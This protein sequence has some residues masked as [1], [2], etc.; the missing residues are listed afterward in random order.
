[1]TESPALQSRGTGT[2]R[3]LDT[4]DPSTPHQRHGKVIG[5]PLSITD[6]RAPR[7]ELLPASTLTA[8][9]PEPMS[10]EN[11]DGR[12]ACGSYLHHS[13]AAQEGDRLKLIELGSGREG[14]LEGVGIDLL[15]Q[16]GG[17]LRLAPPHRWPGP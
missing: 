3:K 8:T 13:V 5:P 7:S 15:R 12:S 6:R 9:S 16:P 14:V 17:Q 1:M 11:L 4:A 10:L 2:D